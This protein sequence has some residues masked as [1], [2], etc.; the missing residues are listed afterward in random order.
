MLIFAIEVMSSYSFFFQ[1][2]DVRI[3]IGQ[4]DENLASKVFCCVSPQS[5]LSYKW[6]L[7]DINFANTVYQCEVIQRKSFV[8]YTT[9]AVLLWTDD[10]DRM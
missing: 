1:D 5:S 7:T 10:L 6:K 4:F 9:G 2:N 3:I 8:W